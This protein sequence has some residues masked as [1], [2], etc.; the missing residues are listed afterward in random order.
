MSHG[1]SRK[2]YQVLP[3]SGARVT[4]VA[5][6][7]HQFAEKEWWERSL[8]SWPHQ[9]A[10][11]STDYREWDFLLVVPLKSVR[12]FWASNDGMQAWGHRPTGYVVP[13]HCRQTAGCPEVWNA[14]DVK[15][16]KEWKISNLSEIEEYI[17]LEHSRRPTPFPEAG[18][19]RIQPTSFP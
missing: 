15:G 6:N 10:P 19:R 2:P 1:V 17:I 12:E 11:R 4:C 18:F 8:Q 3:G 13:D 16:K 14:D 7:D 9:S 5:I